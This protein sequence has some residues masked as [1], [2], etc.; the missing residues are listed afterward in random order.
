MHNGQSVGAA[1]PNNRRA[2]IFA[3]GEQIDLEAVRALI[4]PDDYLI[5]ADGGLRHLR[6]LGLEPHLL[7]GDLDSVEPDGLARLKEQGI[8]VVQY[9]VHKDETDLEL[10]LETALQEGYAHILILGALGGRL[11]MTLANI[12]LLGLPGLSDRDVR[13]DD[14]IEEVFLVRPSSTPLQARGGIH[15]QPGD[16][17]SLLPLGGPAHGVRT[18][19]L[20]YPL[21]GE[22]LYPERTRGISNEM[23]GASAGVTLEVGQLICIHTRRSSG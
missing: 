6:S 20:V 13:L 9:P 14:G 1:A 15:G 12:F 5:A 2:L 4:Q 11:D 21:R 17:V 19:G 7:I 22:T 23:V 18:S 8:R 16:R 10:A 3:N